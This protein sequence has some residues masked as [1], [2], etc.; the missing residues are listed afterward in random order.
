MST[1][2]PK[3]AKVSDQS[4]ILSV[5]ASLVWI[6]WRLWWSFLRRIFLCCR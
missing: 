1:S 3:S 6:P 5:E 4:A 2:T